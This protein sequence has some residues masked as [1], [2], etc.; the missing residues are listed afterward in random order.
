MEEI[1]KNMYVVVTDYVKPDTG[2]DLS[3]VLISPKK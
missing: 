1:M 3:G 2:E